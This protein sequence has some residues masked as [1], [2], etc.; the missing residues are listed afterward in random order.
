MR[1]LDE[2]ADR[3]LVL[4]LVQDL[5][6]G[7]PDVL[8]L[9]AD[10]LERSLDYARPADLGECVRCPAA[11]PPVV[12]LDGLQQELDVRR[13][14]DLVQH[15]DRRSPRALVLV[16]QYL[17]EVEHGIGVVGAHDR[18]DGL[19]LGLDVRIAQHL[20]EQARVGVAV[21]A[22]ERIQYR[23]PD[24]LVRVPELGLQRPGHVR[25]V[26]ARTGC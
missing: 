21:E 17:D 13:S 20:A 26:E 5:D 1:R 10:Q 23:L 18:L 2:V 25:P 15:F 7:A 14:A 11:H 6:G 24:E 3:A 16:L 12:V 8:V 19:L 9:V 22:G 4:G